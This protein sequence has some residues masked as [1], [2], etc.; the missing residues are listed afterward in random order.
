M[1]NY[2]IGLADLPPEGKEFVLDDPTVWQEPL[3]EF[4]MDC[5]VRKPLRATVSV[6]PVEDGWLVRGSL[7][8][9]VVLPCSRCAEDAVIPVAA[10]FEEFESRPEEPEPEAAGRHGAQEA[11]PV[12]ERLIFERGAPLLDLAAVCWE[13]FVLALPSTPL[14]REDCK[15]LC[16][17]CGANLNAGPCACP[18]EEGD[19]RL[20]VLRGLVRRGK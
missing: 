20:A 1:Q 4:H 11:A 2:R 8:G 5:R 14:C 6:T 3:K 15:G 16:A 10:R 19:P 7:E 12:G 9:E 17:R 13:E 18:P